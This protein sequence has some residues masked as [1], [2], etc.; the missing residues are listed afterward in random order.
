MP[1]RQRG[2]IPYAIFRF[3]GAAALACRML[4]A[5][6][7]AV[8]QADLALVLAVDVSSSIDADR[9]KL[10]REGIAAGL[11]SPDVLAAIASGP[12]QTIELAVVE[13]SEE[14]T[15][16]VDWTIVRG[17]TELA[18]VGEILRT[19]PRPQVG[20]KTDVGGALKKAIALLDTAALSPDRKVVDVSGDGEQN[21]G[22]LRADRMRDAAT[23][24]G[25][26][27][28]GLPITSG[29]EPEVDQWYRTHVIGGDGAFLIVANGHDTFCDAMRHKL[30]LEIAGSMPK[31]RLAAAH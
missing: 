12:R 23:A 5:P 25:I 18:R 14:Q 9:F 15:V 8:A 13:W 1:H 26:T 3:A 24:R 17:A 2:H 20:F 27:V 19:A 4:G 10:Q 28:N 31:T 21:A 11:E 22:K 6:D 29:N 7:P 16:L 30:V